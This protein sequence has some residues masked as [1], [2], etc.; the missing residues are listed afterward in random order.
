MAGPS[1]P[2]LTIKPQ[3]PT[4]RMTALIFFTRLDLGYMSIHPRAMDY[5]LPSDLPVLVRAIACGK[6][7]VSR[8]VVSCNLFPLALS[9]AVD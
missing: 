5:A 3:E 4:L 9:I 6:R 1:A 7:E 8:N 2:S